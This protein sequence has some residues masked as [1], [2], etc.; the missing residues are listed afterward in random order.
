MNHVL[1]D[2]KKERVKEPNE[3]HWEGRYKK[4]W[5]C[6]P[7]LEIPGQDI[8][9]ELWKRQS[10]WKL[11]AL[12]I[13]L[14]NK[15]YFSIVIEAVHKVFFSLYGKYQHA[16]MWGNF[17]GKKQ[18]RKWVKWLQA[19]CI[20]G[21]HFSSVENSSVFL[22]R[23]KKVFRNTALIVPGYRYFCL[24]RSLYMSC[25]QFSIWYSALVG[26]CESYANALEAV[27]HWKTC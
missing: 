19:F 22:G 21:T 25:L 4:Q 16:W 10:R 2:M 8:S 26:F 27:K 20:L 13:V 24:N 7:C 9:V 6:Y 3:T 17:L 5:N 14:I 18:S 23:C 12:K 11:T 1:K 15:V